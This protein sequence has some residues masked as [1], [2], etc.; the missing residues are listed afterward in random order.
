M[1][2]SIRMTRFPDRA[3][4]VARASEVV[5][6]PSAGRVEVTENER[7]TPR[8]VVK[9]KLVWTAMY[10]STSSDLRSSK[11]SRGVPPSSTLGTEPSNG[12]PNRCSTSDGS[13]I[14][15]SSCSRAKARAAPRPK[16]ARIEIARLRSK[17]GLDGSSGTAAVSTMAT[18]FTPTPAAT[19]ISLNRCN[20]PSYSAR[21]V[22]TSC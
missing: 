12:R 22:S 19:P 4:M 7:G 11:A 2:P 5:D 18:L 21:F 17:R 20:K 6:L 9:A 13:A 1:S 16:P 3:N 8:S 15:S 10:A 14:A